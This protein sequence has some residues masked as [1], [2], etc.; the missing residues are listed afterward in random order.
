MR[1]IPE[2][3]APVGGF[4]QLRAAAEN[5][6]DA[7][8]MGGMLFNAR[9][10]AQ[11]FGGHQLK[12]AI[13]Y[14]HSKGVKVYMT[15]NTL[16]KDEEIPAAMEQAEECLQA[17]ADALIVAE[18]GIAAL[19]RKNMP[20]MPLHLS[21]QATVCDA[22]GAMEAAALGCSRAVLA[23][24][25]PLAQ[26]RQIA[27]ESPVP[28]EVFVHGALC[29]CY[30]GQCQMSRFQGGRSGNRGSCAQ[31]CRLP[32][33]LWQR[34]RLPAGA[35]GPENRWDAGK[36]EPS[37][38]RKAEDAQTLRS[39]GYL[40][41][42]KDLCTIDHIGELAQA[43]VAS[44]KIEGRMKS[45]EYVAV[46]TGIYRT[47]LDRY[48]KDGEFQV[49]RADREALQQIFSRGDFTE[50]YLW[51]NPR[52]ALLSGSLP[53]H[54]GLAAGRVTAVRSAAKAMESGSA[55]QMLTVQL[56]RE[57]RLG[58]GVEVRGD[59]AAKPEKPAGGRE[60]AVPAQF[61]GGLIT[62]IGAA[63]KTTEQKF[64][65]ERRH[66]KVQKNGG[67]QKI[68]NKSQ[69]E[70]R[71]GQTVEI[72]FFCG[73]ARPGDTVYRMSDGQQLAAARKT[74][75]LDSGTAQKDSR[76]LPV[77]MALCLHRDHP[78]QLTAAFGELSVTVRAEEE[79]EQAQTKPLD[80]ATAHRQLS[81]TGDTMFAL[82]QLHFDAQPGLTTRIAL[83]NQLRR[84]ALSQLTEAWERREQRAPLIQGAQQAEQ[85]QALAWAAAPV[86]QQEIATESRQQ[87]GGTGLRS[88][89]MFAVDET[90]LRLAQAAEYERFYFPVRAFLDD[91][92]RPWISRLAE[93]GKQ[94]I[95]W[96]S[97]VMGP[98]GQR[99]IEK[100]KDRLIEVLQELKIA[101]GK[102]AEA[103]RK[104]CGLSLGNLGQLRLFWG[105]GLPLYGD[106]GLNLYNSADFAWAQQ[107]GFS[108]AVWCHEAFAAALRSS[109][110]VANG[111]TENSSEE[112]IPDFCGMEGEIVVGGRIPLMHSAHCPVGDAT[113]CRGPAGREK[114][115]VFTCA[116]DLAQYELCDR[117]G[118]RYPVLTEIT[119]CRSIIFSRAFP[120][121]QEAAQRLLQRGYHIR[122]YGIDET[123]F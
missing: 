86:Q 2:L 85:G 43:G 69:R 108:G 116:C 77:S 68:A 32:Y 67:Q 80:E 92:Q 21:T 119:D 58:D 59:S 37:G 65:K 123:V 122:V 97:P 70:A 9:M 26:I 113:G 96:L 18:L 31:P 62:Y 103:E 117:T 101:S 5:G 34:R 120:W 41:S 121:E 55:K 104:A 99:E 3:L 83:L 15:L 51:G 28:I 36:N 81:K 39:A 87:A 46:V 17:G 10:N 82:S 53:K 16:I 71:A 35:N 30:S 20:Q 91:R 76:K 106:Y 24:E 115:S 73:Q 54:Q 25:T 56:T 66:P 100:N 47:Y 44:L 79:P 114:G 40:L 13:R 52:K 84:Q 22:A 4:E 64:Q 27:G 90:I 75:T 105:S 42:P 109:G 93:G 110:G 1:K 11:H 6:A 23:R 57:I 29:M 111:G 7:V 74:Y 88:L 89:Y 63:G 72:G 94:V 60:G 112:E 45:P 78:V 107:R 8:Y 12:E 14:A 95:A 49:S 48:Q 102:A 98:N 33:E 61:P 118:S 50:G 38:W 19:L